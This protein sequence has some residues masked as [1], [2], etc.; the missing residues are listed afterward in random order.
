MKPA[1]EK[2]AMSTD[3]ACIITCILICSQRIY[4][5]IALRLN[6]RIDAKIILKWFNAPKFFRRESEVLRQRCTRSWPIQG[7]AR[8]RPRP[9]SERTGGP[10]LDMPP[11]GRPRLWRIFVEAHSLWKTTL[12]QSQQLDPAWMA[13]LFFPQRSKL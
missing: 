8:E 6:N 5:S 11:Y 1:D 7:K 4:L 3:D 9:L 10:E 12:P 2:L 13:F